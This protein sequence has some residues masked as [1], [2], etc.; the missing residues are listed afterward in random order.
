VP[1][2]ASSA[3]GGQPREFTA[4]VAD[5][6]A[7]GSM[8]PQRAYR[9][10]HAA[11]HQHDRGYGQPGLMGLT[12]PTGT[13]WALLP[14]V[15]NNYNANGNGG[16]AVGSSGVLRPD[17]GPTMYQP[18]AYAMSTGSSSCGG[19][20]VHDMLAGEVIRQRGGDVFAMPTP[21]LGAMA[22][23]PAHHPEGGMI[24][25]ALQGLQSRAPMP[26]AAGVPAAVLLFPPPLHAMGTQRPSME[27]VDSSGD[28]LVTGDSHTT[29]TG[30][31]H[32]DAAALAA[33]SSS[34]SSSSSSGSS[35]AGLP[36]PRGLQRSTSMSSTPVQ[37]EQEDE[38]Q[39][40]QG[41]EAAGTQQLALA[42][43]SVEA[44]VGISG[45][46]TNLPSAT[47]M[48]AAAVL[49]ALQGLADRE[50]RSAPAADAGNEQ[51]GSSSSAG[52]APASVA[53]MAG[54]PASGGA[55]GRVSA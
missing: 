47:A 44:S 46:R 8:A 21:V 41:Q 28:A 36:Y 23:A 15:D 4:A 22:P 48:Q 43:S 25:M 51:R 30:S 1:A 37:Q 45:G 31:A 27:E 12:A 52:G 17:G 32:A 7:Y 6:A 20:G 13:A 55:G 18:D 14:G 3:G 50:P 26:L 5:F 2:A 9:V 11:V 54:V 34:S 24:P 38:A 40:G 35:G 33:S 53:A 42:S 49:A 29:A 19:G 39:D 16:A 10:Q